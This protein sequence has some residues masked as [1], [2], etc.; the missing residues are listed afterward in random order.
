[1]FDLNDDGF[2]SLGEMTTYLTSVFKVLYESNNGTKK[3]IGV[4]AD[5]LGKIT[6][7]EAFVECDLNHDG[8]LSFDEFKKWYTNSG[9]ML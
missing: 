7:E 8:R 5:E 2:I 6:A 4:S 9:T 3:A 1:L